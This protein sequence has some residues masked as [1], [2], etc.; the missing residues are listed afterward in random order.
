M[1]KI[2]LEFEQV[3]KYP[4]V[5]FLTRYRNFMMNSYPA[6][7]N[8]FSG[9]THIVENNHLNDLKKLTN[10]CKDVLIQFSNFA[11]KFS[12]CG[13]WELMDYVLELNDIIEKINKLPKYRR[14]SLTKRG[15]K[16]YIQITS[17]IGGF[18][19]AEDV[20]DSIKSSVGENISW[21]DLMLSNDL[22]EFD[23]EID[24]ISQIN[25]MINNTNDVVVNTILDMPIGERV[26]GKDIYR[27]IVFED[28]DILT[29]EY[30]NNIEQKCDILLELNRGDVPENI[31]FGKN[32][33]LFKGVTA[34]QF[35]YPELVNDIQNNFLQNDLFEKAVVNDFNFENGDLF[36]K[37]DIKTK[38][39]Y[40]TEKTIKI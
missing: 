25:V 12:N 33:N 35:A 6:I 40:K 22:N 29:I 14:T 17:S 5:E 28:N 31:L 4:L 24:K 10:D 15:Y 32:I 37:I 9:K 11:N 27:K 18:R 39:D 36:L 38:Y 21:I 26:Y 30:K 3:T 2:I 1:E 19:T 7:D 34:S 8:Y 13:Y 16:P 20:A 23:W